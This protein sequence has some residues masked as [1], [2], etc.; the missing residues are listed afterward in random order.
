MQPHV[1]SVEDLKMD[2]SEVEPSTSNGTFHGAV[3]G[4]LSPI[5][6]SSKNS[7][8]KYFDVRC[9]NGKKTV[10]PVS[11][12]LKLCTQFEEVNK[13]RCRVA[14]QNCKVKRKAGDFELHMN[15]T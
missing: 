2:V 14:L 3:I 7:V 12:D 15:N 11:F 9:G 10:R 5:K 8:V 1:N 4:K 6:T 13:S